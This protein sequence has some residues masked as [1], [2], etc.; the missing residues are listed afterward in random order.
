MAK[1][2][3]VEDSAFDREMLSGVL[4]QDTTLKLDFAADGEEALAKL[5]QAMPDLVITDLVMPKM[6]GLKLVRAIRS[7]YPELPVIIATS[8][9]SE[10]TAFAALEAGAAS[11]VPKKIV[12]GN[13]WQTVRGLLA[14]SV[15]QRVQTNCSIR[16]ASSSRVTR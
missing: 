8:Q 12:A 16:S 15:A 7:Q 9:G 4:K 5:A 6:G 2:L 10:E 13:L 11:Y 1:I 14:I 3:L